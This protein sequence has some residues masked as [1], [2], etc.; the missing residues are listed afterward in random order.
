MP[1]GRGGRTTDRDGP[2]RRCIATGASGSTARLIRFVHGPDGDAVP[3]LA[4]KLPGRGIWLTS[5]RDLVDKAVKKRLFARA[6]RAETAVAPDLADRLEALVADR[7]VSTIAMAR[8]A[9]Q[10]VTGFE[11]TRFALESASMGVL[12]EARD[13]AQDGR[14]KL[15][16]LAQDLP[17]ISALDASELGLAFGRDF[18]IHAA[19]SA[20]AIAERALREAGRLGGLRDSGEIGRS[21]HGRDGTSRTAATGALDDTQGTGPGR[22]LDGIANERHG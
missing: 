17:V 18:A 10:A 6:F 12:I 19:L 14:Q 13:G 8:K 15:R 9:G 3:D 21:S 1:M 20:G 4:E 2:E 7:L 22:A 16:R 11:K 5:E